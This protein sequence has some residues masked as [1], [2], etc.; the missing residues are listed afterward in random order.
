MNSLVNGC[1][2]PQVLFALI[3]SF[4]IKPASPPLPSIIQVCVK[5]CPQQTTSLYA[6]ALAKESGF[7]IDQI[8]GFPDFDLEFQRNLCVPTLTDDEWDR[9]INADNGTLLINLIKKKK[10]PAYTV[11]SIGL[12]GRCVPDFGLIPDDA[13]NT[14]QVTDDN[15]NPIQGEGGI[16]N[17]QDVL[18]SIKSIIDILN[19]QQF[20]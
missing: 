11:E 13:Q 18:D 4:P 20:A 5:E 6:Y 17:M 16:V 1:A 14:T 2:T 12:A 15:N 19:L 7:P 9:A 3:G 8:P 10:C